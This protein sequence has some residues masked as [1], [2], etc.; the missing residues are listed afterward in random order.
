[1]QVGHHRIIAINEA[2]PP[3]DLSPEEISVL[4]HE[5]GDY[6]AAF[7]DRYYRKEQAHWG[8]K[9]LQG[10]MLPIARKSIEPMA[11]AL[12]GGDVQAMPQVMGQ[13]Q[14]QDDMLRRQH[15]RLVDATLGEADGVYIVDGSDVPKPGEHSV[16][17]AR[18][19]CGHWGKV[20]NCQAGVCAAYASRNGSTLLDR[21][22]YLPEEWFAAAHRERWCKCGIPDE[23]RFK[24]KQALALEMVQAIVMEGRLRFQWRTCDEACGRDGT[25]LDG[26]AAL[27]RWYVA[28]VPHD[29]QARL[30]R[31]AT[32]VSTWTGRGRRPRQAHLVPGEPGPQRGDQ[33]A[34]AV[35][36][37]AWPPYLIK[38]G[39][40]GP[41]VAQFAFQRGV[42]VRA[43]LP[44]PDVWLV[45]RRGVGENPELKVYL[46]N[47]PAHTPVTALVRV[48]GMRW[49]IE[50]AFEESQGGLGLDHYEVRSWLGWHHHMTLCLLAHHVLVRARQ[51]VKGGRR[52]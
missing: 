13:G 47:A 22:L 42:A 9:Y 3:L 41:L 31:P 29:T 44:G 16:G 33:L 50:T 11:L 5:L 19:W 24:T 48:A 18:Q 7:A 39:R 6:H 36:L 28:E 52:H 12:D 15:W 37:D 30:T 23:T 46:S 20:D 2:P 26:I 1:M 35:H 17:V 43:G 32:A 4:A 27:G 45:F 10:L 34:A 38:A 51:R 49:P 21:R 8:Y 40:P 14:W 25:F